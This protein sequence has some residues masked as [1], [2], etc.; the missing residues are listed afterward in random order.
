MPRIFLPSVEVHDGPLS[1]K[2][3]K[4]KYLSAVLRCR[5]G[6][7]LLIYDGHGNAYSSKIAGVAAREVLVELIEKMDLDTDSPLHITLLQGLLKG[8]KMDLVVQKATELGVQEIIPVVTERSQL[9]ETRKIPR[10]AR[11]AEEASRQAGRNSVPRIHQTADFEG[12]P[13]GPPANGII[14]WEQGGDNFGA[15][16]KKCGARGSISLFTGPE[17][18]FSEKEIVS[19]VKKGFLVATLGQ[20]I[21]RAETAAITAIAITQFVLGDLGA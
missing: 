15:V 4:A 10:W 20:R 13:P 14:F 1:I 9:R 5:P 11:I 16:L 19:A 12:L 18:G 8:E 2:G 7:R 6:D 3:E 21:L 17:G